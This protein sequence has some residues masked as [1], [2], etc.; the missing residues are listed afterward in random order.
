MTQGAEPLPPPPADVRIV[1]RHIG[2]HGQHSGYDVVFNRLE[3]PQADSRWARRLAEALPHALAWRL[4]S[5]R[6]QPTAKAGLAAELGAAPWLARGKGRL[7]HFIYGEDTYF[8]TP[9]WKSGRNISL[10]TFHYPPARLAERIN[11]GSVRMLD[12]AI[13][14]AN[15]QRA[16][17]EAL[18]PSER[19]FLCL[20]PVDEAFFRPQDVEPPR[21]P[22]LIC[23]G[24]L[25]RDYA[26]LRRVYL[27]LRTLTANF[28]L[29][30]VGASDQQRA[31]LADLPDVLLHKGLSD[32]ALLGLYNSCQVGV[33]PVTDA[34][35][36]NGLL[37]MM[38]C[39][40]PV[41]ATDAGGIRDYAAT[42]TTLC[43][44]GD[45]DAM[46]RDIHGLLEAP[47]ARRERG[48]ANR[49]HVESVLG[50]QPIAARL[51][52]IYCHLQARHDRH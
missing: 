13:A 49:A 37:E 51:I 38:A 44:P 16:L 12:G 36:N 6:P 43:A 42:G 47:G 46:V 1:P 5:M 34:T 26:L 30:V 50:M 10:A 23:V 32:E 48:L 20:H 33:M 7:C 3:L 40:L 45:A 27:G 17:L 22:R 19:V 31:Q 2:H 8:L 52:E 21:I 11:P 35:A 18:L 14:I 15:N 9:L 25:F 39:G 29:H 41:V 24:S 28:E 4:W